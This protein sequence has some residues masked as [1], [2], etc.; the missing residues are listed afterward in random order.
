MKSLSVIGGGSWGTGLAIILAPRF[1]SV[2]QWVFEP[3]LARRMQQNRENDVFLP[4]FRL[5][6]NVKVSSR[7]EE[8]LTRG[9]EVV[10]SVMPSPHVRR[11]HTEM[12]PRLTPEMA[13][14][15]ATK[16]LEPGTL[17]RMSEVVRQVVS[18]RFTPRVAVLSGPNFAREVAA[19]EP[20]AVVIASQDLEL[21]TTI[22]RAFSGP[23][24]RLYAND[25]PVGVELG[26]ALKNI[27]AIAIGICHGLG[28]GSNT[29]AAVMTR[30]LAEITR[31]ALSLG[32][33]ERTL[34]GLAGLGDLVL[35][36][37]GELSRN[38]SVGVEL[39]KGRKL[40]DILGSMKMVAE[41]VFTIDAAVELAQSQHVDMPITMQMH[42]VLHE[43]RDP[44]DAMRELMERRLRIE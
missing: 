3:D 8:V 34:S 19:G 38:R 12:L 4:G 33:K 2:R 7:L 35:T 20:T 25:D 11:L 32:G 29:K 6:E 1:E 39:G 28:W 5:P 22:Q 27:I 17:L 10:L 16:G 43:G 42:A 31:L 40:E 13:L 9:T 24:F 23:T 37:T 44:K 21:A 15:S 36:S 18:A 26:A 41:G 14:V 30:G